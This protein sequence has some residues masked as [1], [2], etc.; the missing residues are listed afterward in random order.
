MGKK[1][2][3]LHFFLAHLFGQAYFSFAGTVQGVRLK[4]YLRGTRHGSPGFIFSPPLLTPFSLV[5]DFPKQVNASVCMYL[6]VKEVVMSNGKYDYIT[7]PFPERLSFAGVSYIVVWGGTWSCPA[8][9]ADDPLLDFGRKH[10]L[11][12]I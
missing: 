12:P 6:L 4:P 1:C 2:I 11:T 9:V 8:C 7:T 3:P 5:C 10:V